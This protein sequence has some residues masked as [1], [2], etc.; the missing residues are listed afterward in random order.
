MVNTRKHLLRTDLQKRHV[1]TKISSKELALAVLASFWL[2]LTSWV[3][4]NAGK[5][6]A[7]EHQDQSRCR[8]HGCQEQAVSALTDLPA[9][10]KLQAGPR[11]DSPGKRLQPERLRGSTQGPPGSAELVPAR[12][13]QLDLGARAPESSLHSE[14]SLALP[15]S[16]EPALS[17]C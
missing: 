11:T 6:Q 1:I 12:Q 5:T 17:S 2:G 10:S 4:I 13:S 8:C 3:T 15:P 14:Y 9:A 16:L 7:Q